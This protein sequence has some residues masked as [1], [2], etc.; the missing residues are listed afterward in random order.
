MTGEKA[1]ILA[2]VSLLVLVFRSHCVNNCKQPPR[3]QKVQVE[4]VVWG[5]AVS[6]LKTRGAARAVNSH[7]RFHSPHTTPRRVATYM[8]LTYAPFTSCRAVRFAS[9]HTPAVRYTNQ[10]RAKQQRR[11]NSMTP[12]SRQH[13]VSTAPT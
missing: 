4:H 12:A 3:A 7:T 2:E 6:T 10:P 9:S 8:S 5:R 13:D 11:V 1:D